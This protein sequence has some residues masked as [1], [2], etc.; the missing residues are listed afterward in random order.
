MKMERLMDGDEM[1]FHLGDVSQGYERAVEAS[2]VRLETTRVASKR[3][4]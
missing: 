4:L 2:C 3:L 1:A